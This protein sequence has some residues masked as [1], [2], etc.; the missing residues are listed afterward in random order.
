MPIIAVPVGVMCYLMIRSTQFVM[1]SVLTISWNIQYACWIYTAGQWPLMFINES[2]VEIIYILTILLVI[3][4]KTN[5]FH[6]QKYEKKNLL[7]NLL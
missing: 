5:N 2:S 4:S 6:T 7:I 1:F 3:N